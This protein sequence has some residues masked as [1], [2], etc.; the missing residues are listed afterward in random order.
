MPRC[1]RVLLRRE[2]KKLPK[3][4]TVEF[5]SDPENRRKLEMIAENGPKSASRIAEAF[6]ALVPEE[7]GEK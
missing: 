6:L 7:K 1:S 5:A 4:E 2:A 3:R